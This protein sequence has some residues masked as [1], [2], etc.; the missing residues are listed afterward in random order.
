LFFS[1]ITDELLP[2]ISA[3]KHVKTMNQKLAHNLTQIPLLVLSIAA[4]GLG[5]AWIFSSNPWL[6]DQKANE[7]LLGLSFET[8]FKS[9]VNQNLPD[10]LRLSYRF[11]GWWIFSIGLLVGTFVQVTRMGTSLA[12][13]AIHIVLLI[14]VAG[15]YRIEYI[16][17]SGSP[18]VFLTHGLLFLIL[19]SVF[20]SFQ[21]RKNSQ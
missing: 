8:L 13:N 6:L 7:A 11:F 19:M 5:L 12:R 20:G 16:Y 3:R 21:L 17:I 4:M 15:I 1:V 9:S 2:Y 14:L 18:F 10:F